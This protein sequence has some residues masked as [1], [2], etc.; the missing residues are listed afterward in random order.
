VEGRA[1]NKK[2]SGLCTAQ[3]FVQRLKT[4]GAQWR[5]ASALA[6]GSPEEGV[7]AVASDVAGNKLKV[8]P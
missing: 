2:A 5:D 1:S 8:Q 4:L 7:D 6:D 3:L